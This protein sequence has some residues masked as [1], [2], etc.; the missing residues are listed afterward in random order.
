MLATVHVLHPPPS[1]IGGFLRVGHTGHRKLAALHA[2]GKLSFNQ[3]VFD[4]A[5]VG[6]QIVLLRALKA[7]AAK[8][9]SEFR[10]D[11]GSRPVRIQR[12]ETSVGQRE[13]TVEGE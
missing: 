8:P 7:R 10:R 5:H 3:F 6:E 12:E 13:C 1:L 9:G 4:A 2:A 11:G